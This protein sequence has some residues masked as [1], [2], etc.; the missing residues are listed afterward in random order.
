MKKLSHSLL[1]FLLLTSILWS[2]PCL[3]A[4]E[5]GIYITQST[6]E[7]PNRVKTLIDQAKEVGI[8]TFIVDY[9]Y[10]NSRYKK[11]IQLVKDNNLKYVARIVI[12]PDGGTEA[13]VRSQGYWE[14]KYELIEQAIALGAQEIQL[15][16]IRYKASQK[17]S[18]QNAQ[19]IHTVIKWFKDKI[20]QQNI[21]LQIDIF[22]ISSFG[23]SKAIGQSPK[24]FSDTVNT[25]CPMVYPSHYYPIDVHS[26]TPYKTIET[27]LTALKKQFNGEPNVRI[28]PYIEVHNYKYQYSG[29]KGLDYVYQQIKAVEDSG[30]NGWYAWSPGNKYQ[31]LFNAMKMFNV[32]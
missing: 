22:G 28:V 13:Q 11:N 6:M 1:Y 15:D 8:T 16:Y 29:Q 2:A 30:V 3:A 7:N 18:P 31:T 25:L 10:P 17:M 12:F 14:K 21:P 4:F 9:V 19:D 20:N 26:A 23:E 5:R 32:K 24:M 27:S